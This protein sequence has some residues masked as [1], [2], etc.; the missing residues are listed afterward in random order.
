MRSIRFFIGYFVSDKEKI[1]GA[2]AQIHPPTHLSKQ[3]KYDRH[4]NWAGCSKFYCWAQ[5]TKSLL[6]TS[7]IYYKVYQTKKSILSTY[8]QNIQYTQ[9]TN[10]YSS[11][12]YTNCNVYLI[13]VNL[14][15]RNLQHFSAKSSPPLHSTPFVLFRGL[16]R[17]FSRCL[18]AYLV[19]VCLFADL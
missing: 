2:H 14:I 17:S 6:S 5:R 10:C 9:H 1:C 3:N 7:R 13:Q 19:Y 11:Y 15:L 12:A 18:S 8:T 4:T 16:E